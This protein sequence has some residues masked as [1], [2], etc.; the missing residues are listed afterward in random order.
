MINYSKL[1]I[2][3]NTGFTR[4][5]IFTLLLVVFSALII[6]A[7][8]IFIKNKNDI[9]LAKKRHNHSQFR[10]FIWA[11]SFFCLLFIWAGELRSLIISVAAILAAILIVSKEFISCFIGSLLFLIS[12]PAKVGDIIEINSHRG[13]LLDKTWTHIE[14]LENS[15]GKTP[16]IAKIPLSMYLT[17]SFYNFSAMG[18]FLLAR[19]RVKCLSVMAFDCIDILKKQADILLTQWIEEARIEADNIAGKKMLKNNLIQPSIE[20]SS[21]DHKTCEIQITLPAPV[22]K[23]KEVEQTIILAWF[24]FLKKNPPK[25]DGNSDLN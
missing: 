10:N 6:H 7:H 1:Q 24:D 22:K 4:E 14:I 5:I 9:D 13:E 11:I 12:K 21:L 20:V 3:F 2:I 19:V 25:N 18:N 15:Y 16:K 8:S 17:S 23:E